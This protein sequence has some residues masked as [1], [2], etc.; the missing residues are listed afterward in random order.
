MSKKSRTYIK[1]ESF[2]FYGLDLPTDKT[3]EYLKEVSEKGYTLC[4]EQLV[5]TSDGGIQ[6]YHHKKIVDVNELEPGSFHLIETAP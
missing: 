3:N 5:L 6:T 2:P 4:S 1:H